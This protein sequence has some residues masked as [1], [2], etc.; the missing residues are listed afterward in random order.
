ME[1]QAH[2]TQ[3]KNR[4][5]YITLLNIFLAI[6]VASQIRVWQAGPFSGYFFMQTF[7]SLAL[8]TLG[9]YG[10]LKWK[11]FVGIEKFSPFVAISLGVIFWYGY[12]PILTNSL[13]IIFLVVGSIIARRFPA[14]FVVNIILSFIALSNLLRL[15]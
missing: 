15:I 5:G 7:M 6:V 4:K 2:Q 1:E 12:W 13:T 9:A 11:E 14:L 10:I 8:L 3:H